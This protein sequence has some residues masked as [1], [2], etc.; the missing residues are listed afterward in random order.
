MKPDGILHRSNTDVGGF[1]NL[2]KLAALIYE[3]S[4]HTNDGRFFTPKSGNLD[5]SMLM[6]ENKV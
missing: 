1:F 3:M 4:S 5:I 6:P 2:S